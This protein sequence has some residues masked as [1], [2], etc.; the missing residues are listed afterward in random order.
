MDLTWGFNNN[1]NNNKRKRMDLEDNKKGFF[2]VE[3]D[4]IYSSGTQIYF[5]SGI[6]KNSISL[7][8][9]EITKIIHNKENDKHITDGKLTISYIVDSPGGCVTSVLKFVDFLN[10]IRKKYPHVEFVSIGTGLIASAGTIMCA[11]ADKRY[12]TS[13]AYAMIHELS[14][15]NAGKF[16]HLV[17]YTKY[18]TQMH[19]KLV[20]IYLEK[21]KMTQQDIESLLKDETWFNADEYLSKG[22]IDGIK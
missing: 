13:N 15:G 4:M 7:I 17:S 20:N 2:E 18:L 1:K 3:N 6:D 11:V 10:I 5:T 9:K 16:T 22:L 14:S 8:I 21:S 19:D 12:M